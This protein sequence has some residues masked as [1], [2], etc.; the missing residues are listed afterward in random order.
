MMAV[1][2]YFPE[3]VVLQVPLLALCLLCHAHLYFFGTFMASLPSLLIY[4]FDD[5]QFSF[6]S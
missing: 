5:L 3:T 1:L 2:L 4:S 6:L